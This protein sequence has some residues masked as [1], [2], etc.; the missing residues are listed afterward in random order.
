MPLLQSPAWK[1]LGTLY[2]ASRVGDMRSVNYF[3][4]RGA[5]VNDALVGSDYLLEFVS[6]CDRRNRVQLVRLC[7]LIECGWIWGLRFS[8]CRTEAV[9][10]VPRPFMLRR[11]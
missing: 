7:V 10:V 11:T 4:A 5:S 2:E 6:S 9:R 1:Q 8:G 3:L